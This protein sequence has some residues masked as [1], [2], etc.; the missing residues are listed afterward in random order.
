MDQDHILQLARVI[1]DELGPCVV[2]VAGAWI[3]VTF[4]KSAFR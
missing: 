1:G 3:I 2:V 4:I